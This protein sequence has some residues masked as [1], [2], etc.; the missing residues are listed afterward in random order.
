MSRNE[1]SVLAKFDFELQCFRVS[2]NFN[3]SSIPGIL[4]G[5]QV[6]KAYALTMPK[7]NCMQPMMSY[8]PHIARLKRE[9]KL[10][11]SCGSKINDM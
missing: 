2:E 10:Y 11:K 7:R 8:E 1:P 6:A 9:E 3:C 4:L 5:D